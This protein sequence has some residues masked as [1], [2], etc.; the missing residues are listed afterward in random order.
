MAEQELGFNFDCDDTAVNQKI[1]ELETI[2]EKSA[3]KR[4]DATAASA[5]ELDFETSLKR[6]EAIVTDMENGQL[7]LDDTMKRFEEGTKLANFCTAKLGE[8]EKR[9]E[10]LMKDGQAPG[11]W[12]TIDEGA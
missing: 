2:D 5:A 4:T 6:L 3:G 7:N 11:S 12:T 8:T 1:D 9:I 10:I